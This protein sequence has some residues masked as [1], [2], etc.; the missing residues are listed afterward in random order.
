MQF[1]GSSLIRRLFSKLRFCKLSSFEWVIL[2][3]FKYR[4]TLSYDAPGFARLTDDKLQ[5]AIAG[6]IKSAQLLSRKRTGP[7]PNDC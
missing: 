2:L 3:F 5:F 1:P 7:Y 4:T 6:C